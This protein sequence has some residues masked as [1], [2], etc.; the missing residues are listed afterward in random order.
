MLLLIGLAFLLVVAGPWR[1]AS[2]QSNSFSVPPING[3]SLEDAKK[4]LAASGYTGTIVTEIVAQCPSGRTR[5]SAGTVCAYEPNRGRHATDIEV[6]LYLQ[7]VRGPDHPDAEMIEVK[8]MT[9][10]AAA[11][12]LA[13]K[14]FHAVE[15]RFLDPKRC[16]QATVC[17]AN[18]KA[19]KIVAKKRPVRLSVGSANA[20]AM[21]K[22]NQPMPDLSGLAPGEAWAALDAI[23]FRGTVTLARPDTACAKANAALGPNR[24]CGQRPAPGKDVRPGS[25]SPV[26]LTLSAGPPPAPKIAGPVP[27]IAGLRPSQ[28]ESMLN[29]KGFKNLQ[30]KEVVEAGCGVGSICRSEPGEGATANFA[31]P[32]IIVMGARAAVSDAAQ[33]QPKIKGVHT[34]RPKAETAPRTG[35]AARGS[36]G[37]IPRIVGSSPS[38]AESMIRAKGF[39]NVE[40]REMVEAGCAVGQVCRTEPGEGV[41]AN[42]G[43]AVIVVVGARDGSATAAAQPQP[44][45]RASARAGPR[46]KRHRE[47]DRRRAAAP[48]K[49][50]ASLARIQARQK[51]CSAPRASQMWNTKMWLNPTAGSERFAAPSQAKA[52]PRTTTIQSLSSSVSRLRRHPRRHSKPRLRAS[53]RAATHPSLRNR[54]LA[55]NQPRPQGETDGPKARLPRIANGSWVEASLE[56]LKKAGFTNVKVVEFKG[57][58][59]DQNFDPDGQGKCSVGKVCRMT[60]PRRSVAALDQLVTITVLAEPLPVLR[61]DELVAFEADP[62]RAVIAALQPSWCEKAKVPSDGGLEGRLVRLLRHPFTPFH[63][64]NFPMV[65]TILCA[66]PDDAIFQ[67]QTGYV[68]QGWANLTGLGRDDVLA[69]VTARAD[70]EA[71]QNSRVD[72]CAKHQV[73]EE[74]SE[75]AQLRARALRLVFGCGSNLAYYWM[76]GDRFDKL[77]RLEWYLD[78]SADG[79]SEILRAFYVFSCLGARVPEGEDLKNHFNLARYALCGGEADML[80]RGALEKELQAG[81]YGAYEKVLAR[82]LF[83]RVKLIAEP[84]KAEA[85]R[86]ANADPAYGE[87]FFNSPKAAWAGWLQRH[88][89]HRAAYAAIAE[90]EGKLFGPS[91]KAVANCGE[92]LRPLVQAHLKKK[93]AASAKTALAGL[94]DATAVALLQ[95]LAACDYAQGRIPTFVMMRKLAN[96]GRL[97]RGPRYAVYNAVLDTLNGI[98]ADRDRFPVS[99]QMLGHKPP[100]PVFEA[101]EAKIRGIPNSS[102]SNDLKGVVKGVEELADGVRLTFTTEAFEEEVFHCENT[103]KIWR[104]EPDGKVKYFR[105]CTSQGFKKFKR[106]TRPV[107]IPKYAAAEIRK[108]ALAHIK[109]DANLQA[110]SGDPKG[111][112][113]TVYASRKGKKLVNYY[114]FAVN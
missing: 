39:E 108:G 58:P 7:A 85:K 100:S 97:A 99:A 109:G 104:I 25:S 9:L 2:A 35:P 29:A 40:I 90:F 30:L 65:L 20:A 55:R 1:D 59:G 76:H 87:L 28:A 60:P 18:P 17:D 69:S 36:A 27:R 8:K 56:S 94:S 106:T 96:N 45:S 31:D 86:R 113:V 74:A 98:G 24:V 61:D 89:R 33:P 19:G 71:W 72:V 26:V 79:G 52:K 3:K 4:K 14:G 102:L 93:K 42:F 51:A 64:D 82:E 105:K 10:S 62:G 83:G 91:R 81:G 11:A 22:Q 103:N 88:A 44:R 23:W 5:Y 37:R 32:V 47:R 46:P 111:F 43:D 107:V 57:P 41:T 92:T 84:Y 66:N 21:A 16:P 75:E 101:A 68:L 70:N 73:G 15:V 53:A 12:A 114:G 63:P 34:S 112:P 78:R 6:K 80:D 95:S 13:A 110:K 54:T 77:S 38:Q 48:A 49:S 50:R 67:K